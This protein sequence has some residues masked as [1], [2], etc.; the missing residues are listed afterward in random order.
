NLSKLE[1]LLVNSKNTLG[2]TEPVFS[3]LNQRHLFRQFSRVISGAVNETKGMGYLADIIPETESLLKGILGQD[4]NV[5]ITQLLSVIK[6]NLALADVQLGLA[7]AD[8]TAQ[9]TREFIGY[10]PALIQKMFAS[11]IAILAKT[12]ETTTAS[13][14]GL[15]LIPEL[16]GI[17]GRR[18]YLVV[19]QNNME[20][21]PTGGFIGSFAVVTLENGTLKDFAVQD[22]YS[23]D[24]SLKGHIDP[25]EAIKTHLGQEHWYM[26]DSNW[27]PD[28]SVTGERLAWF[29]E[30]EIDISVDGVIAL[31]L[32][33][34]QNL[35][36]ATGPIKLTDFDLTITDANLFSQAHAVIEGDFFPGS[37]QKKDFLGAL[38]RVLIE[39][40]QSDKNA[41]NLSLLG[42]LGKS[43]AEKHALLY[44]VNP[45]AQKIADLYGW[46]GVQTGL[47]KCVSC[48][49]DYLMV[50]DANLGVNKVNYFIT[51]SIK[52]QVTLEEN[53]TVRHDLVINY[54]ND[55]PQEENKTSG[56][57]KNYW[58]V[59]VP[60]ANELVGAEVGGSPLVMEQ[61]SVAS[62]SSVLST[63]E[64]AG[65][66]AFAGFIEVGP[67]EKKELHL[68]FERAEAPLLPSLKYDLMVQKQSGTTGDDFQLELKTPPAWQA[69]TNNI[70]RNVAG[71]TS[72]AQSHTVSY[73]TI[74]VTDKHLTFD[75]NK[76]L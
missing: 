29:L 4:N 52:D 21:R 2:T 3:L 71:I 75:L 35:L 57:Y 23:A 63:S 34:V 38:A 50:V 44:L 53:G 65:L 22:V 36:K 60:S 17:Y 1:W 59:F 16:T 32:E 33:F 69:R 8:F 68:K 42:W 30:K 62:I 76:N 48:I 43:F 31:D 13:R 46:N 72:L 37:T 24:G 7:Q 54:T 64:K 12:R 56:T 28:F 41:A 47:P 51:R 73:N 40:I 19:L 74:L 14:G 67:Q 55:S 11:S 15:A 9:E 70:D 39:K 61:G 26:R 49:S 25:P 5:P 20:L 27:D 18:T 66:Q 10:A 6:G 58:R 45:A